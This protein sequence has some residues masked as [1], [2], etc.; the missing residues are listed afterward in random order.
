MQ[1]SSVSW[2]EALIV[3][4]VLIAAIAL[5]K[6]PGWLSARAEGETTDT[7]TVDVSKDG[8]KKDQYT[9]GYYKG[10]ITKDGSSVRQSPGTKD[11]DGNK[12]DDILKTSKGKQVV[13]KK[14]DTVNIYGERHDSDMDV[15]YHVTGEFEGERFDGYVYSTRVQRIDTQI[16]FTPTPTNTPIPTDTPTPK[17]TDDERPPELRP[18]PTPTKTEESQ[19][20]VKEAED[21]FGTLKLVLIL[22]A[23]IA[24]FVII[25]LIVNYIT[26]K[27]ID[28][29]MQRPSSK[30]VYEVDRLEGESE[31]D[32]EEAKRKAHKRVVEREFDNQKERNLN[33]EIGIPENADVDNSEN[34]DD[35]KI[36][37]D[38][39]FDDDAGVTEAVSAV[40]EEAVKD[41]QTADD[42]A[43]A[44]ISEAVANAKDESISPAD[45]E[46]YRNLEANVDE[47]EREILRQIVPNYVQSNT[48]ADSASADEPEEEVL[49]DAQGVP[50]TP[51]EAVIRR[52]LDALKEQET[53]IHRKRGEGEVFDNSDPN[54]IQIRFGRDL[55]YLRKDKLARKKLIEL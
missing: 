18:D 52:K 10:T 50:F 42:A 35:F 29:E 37:L 33:S 45:A 24:A 31:E 7:E 38:G 48:D 34:F 28:K 13:L 8:V 43:Q 22:F 15:W 32:F 25:Y 4:L 5:A 23:G 55:F 44:S 6:L 20:T 3:A 19:Q 11:A 2:K 47:Q 36:N 27:N 21:T 16:T 49:Y 30:K 39:I 40:V 1:R 17:K 41:G 14:N 51:E 46:F 54:I 26:E 53:V 12:K 9:N